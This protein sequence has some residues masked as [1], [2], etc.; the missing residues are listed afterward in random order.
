MYEIKILSRKKFEPV[1]LSHF[2]VISSNKRWFF[3][4]LADRALSKLGATVYQRCKQTFVWVS[5]PLSNASASITASI[6]GGSTALARKGPMGP[7]RSNLIES[8]NSCRGVRKISG[9][10]CWSNLKWRIFFVFNILLMTVAVINIH[11]THIIF[12]SSYQALIY[13]LKCSSERFTAAKTLDW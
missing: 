11:S 10:V 7:S 8:A 5:L 3:M 13:W 9:V 1:I 12:I 2:Q 4:A 6:G